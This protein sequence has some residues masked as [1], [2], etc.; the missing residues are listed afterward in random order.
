MSWQRVPRIRTPGIGGTEGRGGP[1]AFGY[2][3]IDSD[4]PD[5]PVFNW[6]DI[7]TIGTPI[8][9]WTGTDDD[10]HAIVPLPFSFPFYGAGYNQLKVV[11]NGWIGFDVASTSNAYSNTAIPATAEPNLAVYPWWDD[12]D[13]G[14]GGSVHYYDDAANS[15][16]IVQYTNVPHYG[17]TTPGLYTFQV[18]LYPNGN[19]LFQY[20]DMQQTLNS[21]TIGI[22]NAAGDDGLQVVFNSAYVHNNLAISFRLPDAP[23]VSET[24]VVGDHPGRR[25]S[26]HHRDLRCQRAHS[27]I[28]LQ[29]QH[30]HRQRQPGPGRTDSRAG[31]LNVELADSAVLILSSASFT[32]P[33][34]QINTTVHDTITVRNGGL[35]TLN[36]S[37]ITSH[38]RPVC[39]FPGQCDAHPQR[40]RLGGGG[41]HA[42]DGRHRYRAHRVPEQLAGFTA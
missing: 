42:N 39:R 34:Q 23:W 31:S 32:F 40:F 41:I 33:A 11:T 1:D 35:Q 16:F 37:S 12:L 21:A 36:I 19:M 26:A 4:E 20:L 15:R 22:E 9:T 8:T 13:L 2:Q 25:K 28:A 24:P 6:V 27:G 29:R 17:T 5:G 38:K 14:D 7:S 18:I 30:L 3:W 10:G